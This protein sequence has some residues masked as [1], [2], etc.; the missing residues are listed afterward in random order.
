MYLIKKDINNEETEID[1]SFEKVVDDLLMITISNQ[2]QNHE[3]LSY[4]RLTKLVGIPP[5]EIGIN[6]N[7]GF[8]VSVTFYVDASLIKKPENIDVFSDKGNISVDT[9][10]FTRINDYVDVDQ[11]YEI[12]ILKNKL[13]C[14]FVKSNEFKQSYQN[15]NFEIYVDSKNQIVGFSIRDLSKEEIEMINSL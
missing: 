1:I 3:I 13:I 5:L 8:F 2:A 6:C 12:N 4:W 14:S 7:N 10:I 15:G 11:A 9:G